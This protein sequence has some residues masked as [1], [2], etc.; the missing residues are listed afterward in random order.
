MAPPIS[1]PDPVLLTLP[2]G[3]W[4]PVNKTATLPSAKKDLFSFIFV[5]SFHFHGLPIATDMPI[6][7]LAAGGKCAKKRGLEPIFCSVK[8]RGAK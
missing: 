5:L 3:F 2:S 6:F 7:R 1:A 8:G 4:Q